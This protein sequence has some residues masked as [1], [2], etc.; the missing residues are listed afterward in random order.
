MKYRQGKIGRIFM[1]RMDHGDDLLEE[2]KQ[3]AEKEKIE[4]GVFYVIG[5]LKNASLVVGPEECALPPVPVWRRF[6]DC[7]EIIGLGTMV[8]DSQGDPVFHLHGATGRGDI[9]LTGCVRGENE[10]YLVAEV[11]LLELLETGAVK[12]LE[13]SSGLKMLNFLS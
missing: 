13:E 5:A 7:R 3:L 12:E 10:I 11:V 9:T 6:G 2:L 4:A 8:R 1:A